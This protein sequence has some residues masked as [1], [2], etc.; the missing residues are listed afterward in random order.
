MTRRIWL[1]AA[2]LAATVATP[3]MASSDYSCSQDWRLSG[4]LSESAYGVT[5]CADRPLLWPGNDTRS[6]LFL[7]L[8][9]GGGLA[10]RPRSYAEPGWEDRSFGH[11]FF[12]WGGIATH[13]NL[14]IEA[15]YIG[16]GSHC[17]SLTSGEEA[18]KAALEGSAGLP[19]DER[20]ALAK[21][22]TGIGIACTQGTEGPVW[23]RMSSAPGKAFLAYLESAD[24]FYASDWASARDGFAALSNAREPWVAETAT[25]M[26]IRVELNAAQQPAFDEYGDFR[27][28]EFTD[29]V[30][31]GRAGAAISFYL[32]RYPAGFY[33]A[34]ATGL[35]RRVAWLGGDYAALAREYE[36]ALANIPPDGAGAA[37]LIQEIDN[38]LLWTKGARKAINTPLLLAT[39]D[40]SRMRD[41][42]H[43]D[44][45]VLTAADLAAQKAV[46][47]RHPDLFAYLNAARALYVDNDAKAVL[48]LVPAR[49][50][51]RGLSPL[52]YSLQGLRGMALGRLRDPSEEAHWRALIAATDAPYAN[53]F[54]QLGL[55]L[56]WQRSNRLAE[57]FARGSP[58]SDGMIRQIL[59]ARIAGQDLLRAAIADKAH[60]GRTKDIALFTLLHKDLA[61]GRFADFETDRRLL[62]PN[63]SREGYPVNLLTNNAVPVG[64]FAFGRWQE[65]FA[66][67]SID[68]TA[69]A[70]A[71]RSDDP[72]ARLC[73]AEFWRLNGF[74]HLTDLD[75]LPDSETLGGGRSL[76]PGKA[77]NRAAIY[78][79]VL[80]NP[81]AGADES[82]YALFRSVMCYA[83]S[84]N[85]DCGGEDVPQSAR[86]AWYNQLK[87]RF[88]ASRWA[89]DLR[90]Y[91]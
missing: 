60:D 63:A 48:A 12:S 83:P 78:A 40:L 45:K 25:Y 67:P 88:P 55:A 15:N 16:S 68:A 71:A 24:A 44:E 7:L 36:L 69:R 1:G 27:G 72:R 28:P 76:F 43:D 74:D 89:Q 51:A 2:L 47:A 19:A 52:A 84:G 46:F 34:S 50:P 32:K 17:D 66:C 64:L 62:P 6:N 54:A 8:R 31:L 75:P 80:A 86:R 70:L 73:L 22:R 53:E 41:F 18:F 82:A 23:P 20:S 57:I 14:G 56:F 77:T 90:Y 11:S 10:I 49:V 42:T 29:K 3:G 85:N 87:E 9:G 21:L 35:R 59:L 37:S 39:L 58:V 5:D 79:A 38:K 13:Y 4:A 65:K 33:T 26:A 81:R 30:A 61:L 91:W